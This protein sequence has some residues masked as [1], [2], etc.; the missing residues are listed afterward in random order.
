MNLYLNIPDYWELYTS[1]IHA[2]LFHP[3]RR[4]TCQLYNTTKIKFFKQNISSRPTEVILLHC[5]CV[6]LPAIDLRIK[7]TSCL[8]P[9]TTFTKLQ[10]KSNVISFATLHHPRKP[11]QKVYRSLVQYINTHVQPSAITANL[12]FRGWFFWFFFRFYLLWY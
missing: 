12:T 4:P 3:Y 7:C 9:R 6:R 2:V 11:V 10:Q 1:L 5:L 8:L